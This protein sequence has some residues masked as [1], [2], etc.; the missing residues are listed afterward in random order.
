M[1][2]VTNPADEEGLLG[3]CESIGLAGAPKLQC[4]EQRSFN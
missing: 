3:Y 4:D 1:L 2:E